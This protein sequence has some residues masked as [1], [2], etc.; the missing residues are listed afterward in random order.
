MMVYLQ[1][2]PVTFGSAKEN[3]PYNLQEEPAKKH[4][5]FRR[6]TDV[7]HRCMRIFRAPHVYIVTDLLT[8]HIK[9]RLVNG[10]QLLSKL[11]FL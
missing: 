1:F 8:T 4:N 11:I 10:K 9:L 5:Y 2:S 7:F 6:I 3:G